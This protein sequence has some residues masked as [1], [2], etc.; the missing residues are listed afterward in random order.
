MLYQPVKFKT[1]CIQKPSPK[2][3]KQPQ[4]HVKQKKATL[5]EYK[6]LAQESEI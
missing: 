4:L 5:E 1:G 3:L 6:Q 2:G